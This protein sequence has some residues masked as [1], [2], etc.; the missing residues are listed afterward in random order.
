MVKKTF[1]TNN[2]VKDDIKRKKF[3]DYMEA[4]KTKLLDN[5][6]VLK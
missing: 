5:R 3:Q 4:L 6:P 1:I 2:Q